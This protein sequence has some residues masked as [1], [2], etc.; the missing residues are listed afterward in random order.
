[1]INSSNA[2]APAGLRIKY[3]NPALLTSSATE[4]SV[5]AVWATNVVLL[6]HACFFNTAA[7]S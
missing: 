2:E 4:E 5:H 3:P 6:D 1:V 7:V